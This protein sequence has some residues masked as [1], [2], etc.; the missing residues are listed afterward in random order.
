MKGFLLITRTMALRM[1]RDLPATIMLLVTPLALIP[2]LGAVFSWI[3]AG[4]PYLRGMKSPMAFFA[5][6]ILIMFQL[7]GGAYSLTYVK[8]ALLSPMKWRMYSLPCAP[9]A[10]VSGVVAAAT[11]ISLCQGLLVIAV[12][13]F[14]LGVQ[15]G[16]IAL[17]FLIL[18][19]VSLLSQMAN[20]AI[21][22]AVRNP[23]AANGLGWLY[24]YGSCIVGGLIFPFPIDKPVFHFL[25]AWGS[26][27]S[28]AQTAMREASGG[29][30]ATVALCIGM[31]FVLAAVC[32]GLAALLGRRK[33]A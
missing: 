9:I 12:A 20:V 30:A 7:F 4:V 6:G 17:V 19:G 31:L 10:I 29:S 2:L 26:P 5:F 14:F 27:Y 23:S 24:A 22:L 21:L 13:R 1:V 16:N 32:M 25:V 3:P 15:W 8:N 28:L 33:L 18:L 11:L